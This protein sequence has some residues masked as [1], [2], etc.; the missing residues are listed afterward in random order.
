LNVVGIVA[1]LA[2]EARAL[3]PP[4]SASGA[5]AVL[6]DGTL[7][8]VSGIGSAAAEAA[9]CSLVAA[10]ATALTSWGMAGGLDPALGAGTIFL[11]SAV[12]S[13]TGACIATCSHWRDSLGAA[14]VSLR[15]VT[16]GKLLTRSCAIAAVAGKAAAFRTT[17][18]LAVD[19]ESAAVGRIAAT[20]GLPFIAIRVIVDTAY[21]A[22]PSAVVA[23]SRSGQVQIWRLMRALALAPTDLTALV[24]LAR[25]YRSAKRSLG[26]VARVGSL[27]RLAFPTTV[28]S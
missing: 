27:A 15:P 4:K 11:P 8:V 26:A 2:A 10:G 19:M 1:A 20:H 3:A 21:D 24:G 17:G 13:E 6:A 14:I 22:L 25:R 5:T 18:A 16:S 12:I 9:A 23:A 28:I 7:L